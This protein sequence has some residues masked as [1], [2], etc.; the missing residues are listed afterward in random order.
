MRQSIITTKN[1]HLTERCRQGKNEKTL[2]AL[3]DENIYLL[4]DICTVDCPGAHL[5]L[6]LRLQKTSILN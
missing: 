5:T 1:V 4:I 6:I 2:Q 3:K